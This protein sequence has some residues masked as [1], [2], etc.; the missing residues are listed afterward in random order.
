MIPM[1]IPPNLTPEQCFILFE[2]ADLWSLFNTLDPLHLIHNHSKSLLSYLTSYSKQIGFVPK[3][4]SE[5]VREKHGI[6]PTDKYKA[7]D[8]RIIFTDYYGI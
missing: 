4:L 5:V 3:H 1:M 6:T 2:Q 8:W 7:S